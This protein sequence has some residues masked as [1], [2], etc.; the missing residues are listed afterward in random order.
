MYCR[1]LELC[2]EERLETAAY[3]LARATRAMAQAEARQAERQGDL[4]WTP[5]DCVELAREKTGSLFAAA[6][7][8]GAHL[9]AIENERERFARFG[10]HIGTA[11]Q[12]VDD[13]LD[14]APVDPAWGK[15]PLQ[16]L[17]QGRA[18]L[19]LVLALDTGALSGWP[20]AAEATRL[21]TECG[22]LEGA[23]VAARRQAEAARCL[24]QEFGQ[25]PGGRALTGLCR[26]VTERQT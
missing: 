4:D 19:P 1:A 18:T 26:M 11:Y 3:L 16:D 17:R 24:L 9:G 5:D 6:G 12:I 2:L 13:V 14:Y 21:L 10:A 15:Q 25:E 8:L 7:E 22:A 23:M 20:G